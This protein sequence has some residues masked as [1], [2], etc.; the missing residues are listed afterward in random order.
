MIHDCPDAPLEPPAPTYRQEIANDIFHKLEAAEKKLDKLS[1]EFDDVDYEISQYKY[2]T[3]EL[4]EKVRNF[5]T[6]KIG[7]LKE[8]I[9]QTK[10]VLIDLGYAPD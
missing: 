6:D 5:Y 10:S 8:E 4:K 1:D 3:D 9:S 2:L 7:E